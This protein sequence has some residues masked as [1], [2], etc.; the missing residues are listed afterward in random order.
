M[1]IERSAPSRDGDR[2]VAA[3]GLCPA[4]LARR[5]LALFAHK[6]PLVVPGP[7]RV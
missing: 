2:L 6:T 5:F 1:S 4:N 7:E 3:N